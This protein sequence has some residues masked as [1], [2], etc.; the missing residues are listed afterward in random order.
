[1]KTISLLVISIFSG[2]MLTAQNQSPIPKISQKLSDYFGNYPIEKV[3]LMTDKSQYKPGETIWFNAFISKTVNQMSTDDAGEIFIKLYDNKGTPVVQE[4]F[5][6][7]QGSAPGDLTIPSDLPKGQYFLV[8]YPSAIRFPEEISCIPISINPGYSN[9]WV[10]SVV[11]RDSLSK[12]GQKNELFVV[13][14]EVS[15]D[16]KKNVLLRYQLMNGAEI[17]EKG[18]LR[19][20]DSGKVVIPFQIP[21]KTNGEPFIC[22]LSDSRDEWKH[23][24]FLPTNIDPGL[25]RFYPEGGNL[26]SGVPAKIGFTAFNKWGI[27]VDLE[28]S[29]MNQEGQKVTLVKTFTKGLGLFSLSPDVKQKYRLLISGENGQNQSFELPA[30]QKTSPAFSVTKTDSQFISVNLIFTDQQKHPVALTVTQDGNLFWAADM[31]INDTGRI[32]IPTENIPQGIN[33]LSLF[34]NEGQLLGE[35]IVFVDKKQRLKI[36]VNPLKNKLSASESIKVSVRLTDENNQPLS[37]NITISIADQF[38]RY[39]PRP[40][41]SGY[42]HL[43]LELENPIS[44]LS[45]YMGDKVP[46][47][48]LMDV[49]LIANR[50]RNFDWERIIRFKSDQGPVSNSLQSGISGWVTDKNGNKINR[51]K[52]SLVNNK[53]MQLHTTTTNTDGLFAFSNLSQINTEDFSIKATDPEGKREL[54]VIFSK[55]ID[56]QI[57]D[58]IAKNTRKYSLLWN[59]HPANITYFGN[60]EAL[61]ERTPKILKTNTTKLDNQRNMLSMSTNLMDVIKTIKPY[62]LMNNQIVFIGSENSIN[63]QGGA[64]IVVDGQQMGTDISSVTHISPTE[65]DHINISTN[66]MDIQRYT[67]FNSVGVIEIF[68]KKAKT[69]VSEPRRENTNKYD[70]L[71]RV[72]NVFSPEPANPKRD[73]RTTL[74]WMPNQTVDKSGQ[75]EFTLTAGKVIS[76]FVIEVQGI[77]ANGRTGNAKALVSV[78]K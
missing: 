6:I 55:N 65:V 67:G 54:K 3:F 47:S 42:P 39:D 13:I 41:I 14:Q 46:N 8:A 25:I 17:I 20:D 44:L 71:Y 11:A 52:V 1:M 19:T 66:P 26:T 22:E 64:L 63:Y 33:L 60:N 45:E 68:L 73:T 56:E 27:P 37:G 62:R 69:P 23:Q 78:G 38:K 49:F 50:L 32:K 31:E 21:A 70:G 15:G 10:A 75:F 36:E 59:E 28:G 43:D 48:M 29:V 74:L 53:N 57:S 12:A 5:R 40:Q 72:P 2:L 51:A 58:Y 16:A 4:I 77:A 76:D 18:K 34:S 61:F 30:V 24:I 35:R 9:Q 7:T